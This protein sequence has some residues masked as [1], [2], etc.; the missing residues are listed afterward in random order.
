MVSQKQGNL[1][2]DQIDK[3]IIKTLIDRHIQQTQVQM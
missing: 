1:S 3:E 2:R